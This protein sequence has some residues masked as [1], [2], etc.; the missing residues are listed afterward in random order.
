MLDF[1][2]KK[3]AKA[4]A[5]EKLDYYLRMSLPHRNF[6]D[7]DCACIKKQLKNLLN[8]CPMC[9]LF[10]AKEVKNGVSCNDCPL[11]PPRCNEVSNKALQENIVKLRAWNVEKVSYVRKKNRKS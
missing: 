7:F 1:M 11:T 2:T 3:K 5:L 10:L 6:E 4:L 8:H 9:E